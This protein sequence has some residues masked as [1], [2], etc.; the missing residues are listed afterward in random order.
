MKKILRHVFIVF[1]MLFSMDSCNFMTNES[2]NSTLSENSIID[3]NKSETTLNSSNESKED[4]MIDK[5]YPICFDNVMEVNNP[6]E[7]INQVNKEDGTHD[8]EAKE[9]GTIKS[10]YFD[11]EI[12]NINVPCYMVRSSLGGHSFAQLD[13][14]E[15]SFP[16]TC[17]VTL[18]KEAINAKI[19]PLS[20]NVNCYFYG[21]SKLKIL[22]KIE[23]IGNYT[24]VIDNNKEKALTIFVREKEEFSLP[25]FY[26]LQVIQPGN[27]EKIIS[28]TREY[29]AIYFKKGVHNLKYSINF[30]SNTILYLEEG[31]YI[32]A[33][34]PDAKEKPIIESDWCNMPRYNALFHG[35]N[36][37][38]VQIIGKGMID[39]SRLNF[40]ARLGICFDMSTNITIK[41]ITLNNSPEWTVLFTRSSN[42][43][44][45]RVLLF[46]YRQNSDGICLTDSKDCMI[47]N[48]F[49]R[50]GDD[51]FE[52]KSMYGNYD[53]LIENIQFI[54]NNAWPDKA[55]GFGIIAESIRDINDVTFKNC[56]I[57]FASA[58]WMDDLG[59]I[60][61]YPANDGLVSNILFE[62][63]EIYNSSLYPIA[64]APINESKAVIKNILFKNIKIYDDKPIKV[65][66]NANG[67]IEKLVFDHCYRN[68]A[69]LTTYKEYK[70]K[71]QN[72]DEK[73]IEIK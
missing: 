23:K 9:F 53:G 64:I 66:L 4:V 38:N 67:K 3:E 22:F 57:G 70:F 45:D 33:T 18:D 42:I 28:F 69:L 14:I 59:S 25:S 63:M 60:V 11:L 7:F 30:K 62:N 5:I 55:R 72:Y 54:N 20:S 19:L 46:G 29:E 1:I 34:M 65:A 41:D 21:K 36:V 61:V 6:M 10:N 51:L 40:H 8:N 32:Y 43:L 35:E 2:S 48:C 17:I 47:S 13:I 58:T 26:K 27:H 12:N 73:N 15:N 39:L 24:L 31:A 37:N 56:A 52:V 71:T 50:S 44:V 16:H 49:A 68:N